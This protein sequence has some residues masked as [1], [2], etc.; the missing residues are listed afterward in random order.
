MGG[1]VRP[2]RA[3]GATV[4]I[5]A[6]GQGGR[7]THQGQSVYLQAVVRTA[8]GREISGHVDDLAAGEGLRLLQPGGRGA[9]ASLR[10]VIR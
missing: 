2:R 10:V 8:E 9:G 3:T 1:S 5:L 4:G 6:Q 7:L